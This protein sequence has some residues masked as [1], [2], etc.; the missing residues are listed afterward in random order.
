MLLVTSAGIV[1]FSL[2]VERETNIMII[3]CQSM[4]HLLPSLSRVLGQPV[5]PVNINY[6]VSLSICFNIPRDIHEYQR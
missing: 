1:Y 6:V 3:I 2:I 4:R 5:F